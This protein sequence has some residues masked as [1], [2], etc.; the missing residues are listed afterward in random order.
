MSD[1]DSD[2]DLKRAIA[3]SLEEASQGSAARSVPVIDLTSDDE[4]DDLD[5][6]VTTKHVVPIQGIVLNGEKGLIKP[7]TADSGI[8]EAIRGKGQ[9][10]SASDHTVPATNLHAPAEAL[11]TPSSISPLAGISGM[12]RKQME[13]ERLARAVMRKKRNGESPTEPIGSRKRKASASPPPSQSQDTRQTKMS[14]KTPS[15]LAGKDVAINGA[16]PRLPTHETNQPGTQKEPSDHTKPYSKLPEFPSYKEQQKSL[17]ASGIK[18]PDGVVKR[19]WAYGFPRQP[20]DIKFEEVLQ[21]ND[22]ELAVLSAFQVDPD[23]VITKLDPRT[24]V[25]WVLQAKDE[26]Q[27][28][29][30]SSFSPP[31]R[32]SGCF[33]IQMLPLGCFVCGRR[34]IMKSNDFGCFLKLSFDGLPQSCGDNPA[35]LMA[36]RGRSFRVCMLAGNTLCG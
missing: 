12:N 32:R 14:L 31:V 13:E 10:P 30:G 7:S 24:K 3:L 35:K 20:D 2:E 33:T 34:H 1:S 6:P 18:Y 29:A 36:P 27:V 11:P 28:S 19:T 9:L 16:L 8:A 26:A 5:A 15:N 4:D 22:L 25:I 21:K 17:G 23:W